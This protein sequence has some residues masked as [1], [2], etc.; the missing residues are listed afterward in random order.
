MESLIVSDRPQEIAFEVYS[1]YART[2]TQLFSKER[3]DA[4]IPPILLE[5]WGFR[6]VFINTWFVS[7]HLPIWTGSEQVKT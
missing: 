1:S 6:S 5:K 2:T 3:T 7:G 4:R